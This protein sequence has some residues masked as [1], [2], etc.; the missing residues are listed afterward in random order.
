MLSLCLVLFQAE[1]YQERIT[2]SLQLLRIPVKAFSQTDLVLVWIDLEFSSKWC[3]HVHVRPHWFIL[4]EECSCT[5]E[6]IYFTRK[7]Y[8][9]YSMSPSWIWSDKIT[10]ERVA[11]VG[12]NHFIS[13]K[14][15]WNNCLSK[16]SNRVLPPIFISTILQSVRKEHTTSGHTRPDSR[17]HL[18]ITWQ[19]AAWKWQL[20]KWQSVVNLWQK[21]SSN[22][23]TG[24]IQGKQTIL[25]VFKCEES[26]NLA[27]Y[28]LYDVKLRL[29]A[30][31][32]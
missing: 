6:L 17:H 5:L 25:E 26:L 7:I 2:R 15:E 10:N 14:G 22:Y 28:F 4:I 11:L 12:C 31:S 1:F 20:R 32:F 19:K 30:H 24:Q 23:L 29:L 8:N 18:I 16:F 13:N 9:N 3:R 27:Y 21:P